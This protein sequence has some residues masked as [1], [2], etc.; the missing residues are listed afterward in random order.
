MTLAVPL[1]LNVPVTP[2][3]DEARRLVSEELSQPGYR[4]SRSLLSRFLEWLANLLTAGPAGLSVSWPALLVLLGV[5]AAAVALALV[6]AGPLRRRARAAGAQR[7]VLAGETRGAAELRAAA[8]A[9]ARAG[10]WSEAALT[11]FRAVARALEERGVLAEA[12]GRTA[13]EIADRA[14]A[15]LGS[16]SAALRDGAALFDALAYGG[17]R[18]LARHYE[19]MERLDAAVAAARPVAAGVAADAGVAAARPAAGL[20]ADAG[21]AAAAP[22]AAQPGVLA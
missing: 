17:R 13:D 2:G 9:S 22:A 6:L 15:L 3:A 7:G 20:A 19:T 18:G 4:T 16:V 14:G 8:A 5:T 10:E 11:R 12:P 21:T 1:P